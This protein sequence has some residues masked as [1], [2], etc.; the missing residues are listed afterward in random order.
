L[1]EADFPDYNSGPALRAYLE[2]RGLSVLKRYGQNFLI[3]PRVRKA[4]IDALELNGG[5]GV[6][7][8]GPG[9]GAMTLPLL[10]G[11]AVVRAF[12][13][14]GGVSALLEQLFAGRPFTLVRGDVLKT[15]ESRGDESPYLLGNLPYSIAA[16]LMGSFIEGGRF[17]RRMVITVQKELAQRMAASPGSK[18]YASLSV[19][20]SSAYTVRKLMTLKG[21]SFYPAPHVESASLQLTL[22]PGIPRYGALFFPLVRSLF[23]FRRKTAANNLEHFLSQSCIMREA[24]DAGGGYAGQRDAGSEH[25]GQKYAVEAALRESG[26]KAGARAETLEKEQFFALAACL[27]GS[28]MLRKTK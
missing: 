22:R 25:G 13:I 27:E 11:G 18:D 8:I 19:L 10:D 2:R 16:P 4:L 7:E 26:I 3:N 17:F 21:A 20:L 1:R 28:F 9:L 15:W 6:W 23:E 14:D 24:K 5:D 12:E